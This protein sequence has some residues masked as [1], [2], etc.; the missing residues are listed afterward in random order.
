[1]WR[2]CVVEESLRARVGFRERDGLIGATGQLHV[3]KRF[4]IHWEVA[5][6][7]AVFGSHVAD[8]G[9]VGQ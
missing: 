4:F 9:A 8:R 3:A 2:V 1:M 6:G 7:G 5:D